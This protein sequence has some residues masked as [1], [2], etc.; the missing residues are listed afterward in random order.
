[1]RFEDLEDRHLLSGFHGIPDSFDRPTASHIEVSPPSPGEVGEGGQAGA[2]AS[3][4]VSIGHTDLADVLGVHASN[5]GRSGSGLDGDSSGASSSS[6]GTEAGVVPS[7]SEGTTDAAETAVSDTESAAIHAPAISS[8]LASYASY[9]GGADSSID[10][11]SAVGTD[12]DPSDTQIPTVLGPISTNDGITL[13]PTRGMTMSRET[14][15]D[16]LLSSIDG[17][18]APTALA[19]S[20]AAWAAPGGVVTVIGSR[21]SQAGTRRSLHQRRAILRMSMENP[22]RAAPA[23]SPTSSPSS[24]GLWRPPSIASWASSIASGPS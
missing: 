24:G 19:P 14:S 11:I 15:Y 4:T 7:T 13:H 5:P 2:N 22:A 17:T 9:I 3:I 10:G 23:S 12:G 18:E 21:A 16:G 1:M 20:N 6:S 8:G